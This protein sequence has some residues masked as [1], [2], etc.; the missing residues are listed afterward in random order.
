MHKIGTTFSDKIGTTFSD[1]IAQVLKNQQNFQIT[2]PSKLV[3]HSKTAKHNKKK[4]SRE[5][6][7]LHLLVDKL[8]GI[9]DLVEGH[10]DVLDDMHVMVV[11]PDSFTLC[12]L[13]E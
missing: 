9:T 6:A 7:Y 10:E 4:L 2:N 13:E 1:K 8:H 12:G 11:V 5:R 3:Q